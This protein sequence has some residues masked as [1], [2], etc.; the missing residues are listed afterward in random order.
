MKFTEEDL[1]KAAAAVDRAILDNLPPP[2]EPSPQLMARLDK[3]SAVH[4]AKKPWKTAL[5]RVAA[6]ILIVFLVGGCWLTVDAEARNALLFWFR[7]F[8]E[9]DYIYRFVETEL[10]EKLPEYEFGWLPQGF[11]SHERTIMP[12]FHRKGYGNYVENFHIIYF[13]PKSGSSYVIRP[14][15]GVTIERETFTFSGIQAD[16]YHLTGSRVKNRLV[17]VDPFTGM[18]FELSGDFPEEADLI[19]MLESL[20]PVK[21]E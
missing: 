12:S 18:L 21:S 16:F 8:E 3:L 4:P 7:D 14:Y 5:S 13:Y 20:H 11:E 17:W 19:R 9:E 15:K 10:H 6:C 1:K 2:E